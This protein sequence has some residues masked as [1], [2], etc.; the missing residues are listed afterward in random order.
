[1]K[2]AEVP[3]PQE[4]VVGSNETDIA[5]Q[6]E[7][8]GFIESVRPDKLHVL[9]DLTTLLDH[10]TQRS[11]GIEVALDGDTD[12]IFLSDEFAEKLDARRFPDRVEFQPHPLLRIGRDNSRQQ[13]F[14]GKL[15]GRWFHEATEASKQLAV[16]PIPNR[17]IAKQQVLHEA[18]M[19]QYAASQGLPTLNVLGIVMIAE[20]PREVAG[21]LLTEFEPDFI[22]LDNLDWSTIGEEEASA[23][24]SSAL[25]SLAALH[26]HLLFHGDAE[27]KNIGIGEAEDAFRLVD[28]EFGASA[29][30]IPENIARIAQF[31]SA[32]FSGIGKSFDEYVLR[33]AEEKPKNDIDRF[34]IHHNALYEPYIERILQSNSEHLDVLAK[35][36]QVVI[37]QKEA[38]ARGEW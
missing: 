21:Y 15:T 38:Q 18:A 25:D 36:Y 27:F 6:Q 7:F 8:I 4:R 3:A 19:Y 28:F 1:M 31:I 9:P 17:F 35:A 2:S 20:Q 30:A 32:D 29:Q 5:N 37:N 16:K 23:A 10:E 22:T 14:F 12:R 24:V 13:V 26:S 33:Y 11:T 34:N